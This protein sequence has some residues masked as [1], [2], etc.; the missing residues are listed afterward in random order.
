MDILDQ[1]L[2]EAWANQY[3][4]SQISKNSGGNVDYTAYSLPIL[5]LTGDI[6][7]MTKDNAVDLAYAYGVRS[8]TAS[9]KWQ[10]NSS[11][12]WDKKNYTIKFD[13]AFEAK[14]GWGAQKKY[15]FK[16]NF[17]DHSHARNIVN[18]KLWGEVVKSRPLPPNNLANLPNAGAIDG[19]PCI[20]ILNGEFLGLFT[21]NIPKDGWM[22]G[23]DGTENRAAIVCAEYICDATMFMT[24]AT[25]GDHF[26][27]EYVTNE[28]DAGWVQ[29][30][31]NTLINACINSD[32]TDL[33]TVVAK[34]IDWNSVI[35]FY[36]FATLIGGFDLIGKNYLLVTFDGIKWRMGAYDMDSTHGLDWRG[37]KFTSVNVSPMPEE[38]ATIHHLMKLVRRY[39]YEEL[40]ERYKELRAGVLSDANVIQAFSNFIATIPAEV[41]R[42][43]AEKWR[44]IPS[45]AASNLAQISEFYRM[46]AEAVDAEMYS[47]G[48]PI[49]VLAINETW[50]KGTADPTTITKINFVSEYT[51]TGT[52]TESWDASYVDN[53]GSIKGYVTGDT[54]IVAV[55]NGA[56]NIMLYGGNFMFKAFTNVTEITGTEMFVAR[57]RFDCDMNQTCYLLSKLTTPI[58]IPEGVTSVDC[59][60]TNC[61][62]LTKPSNIPTTVRS[63][64]RMYEGCEALTTV[65]KLPP[66]LEN[67]RQMF[68]YCNNIQNV[69]NVVVP[70]TVTNISDAFD[71]C[72]R[73][74]GTMKINAVNIASYTD[75]F[76][77]APGQ[78]GTLKL[79]GTSTQL[80]ELAATNEF[81]TTIVAI[82]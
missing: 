38:Y 14:E 56:K 51:E 1:I 2:A 50:Y 57:K 46:R 3:T 40:V 54:V 45:T 35:D 68:R 41:Y 10:G 70:E 32:G 77:Q 67:M 81:G 61:K 71:S 18:A 82:T 30:S 78:F 22:F 8:G 80:N 20:I 12:S 21:W 5:H 69:D 53:P 23:I 31:L 39:K 19:F 17:I 79:V 55:T 26:D 76:R 52:E 64:W 28:D 6:S 65:P 58:H 4:D 43:D 9:V 49:P 34:Y 24:E 66:R 7:A 44:S 13:N 63:A 74:N 42:V 29:T 15:C 73:I 37:D 59:F 60:Y 36:C 48:A 33:D 62:A 25:I 75:A 11:L 72:T 27:L 16:A 47:M